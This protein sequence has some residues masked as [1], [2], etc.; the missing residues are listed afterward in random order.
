[1][2]FVVFITLITLITSSLC[3]PDRAFDQLGELVL[4]EGHQMS[5]YQPQGCPEDERKRR[6]KQRQRV[7]KRKRRGKKGEIGTEIEN[8]QRKKKHMFCDLLLEFLVN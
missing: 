6:R 3:S 7:G 5:A 4:S 2:I 1:M 8:E